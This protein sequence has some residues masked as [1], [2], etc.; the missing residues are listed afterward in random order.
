MNPMTKQRT[1]EYRLVSLFI[2]R[3]TA[4]GARRRHEL[5]NSLMNRASPTTAYARLKSF[6]TV[7]ERRIE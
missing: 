6:Y 3:R 4:K 5:S 1:S 2:D 7:V